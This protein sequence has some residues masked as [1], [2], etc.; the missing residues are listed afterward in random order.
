[1]V[2]RSLHRTHGVPI[3]QIVSLD[4]KSNM[5]RLPSLKKSQPLSF[6]RWETSL[7]PVQV[8]SSSDQ[9]QV[10]QDDFLPRVP[11]ETPH[12]GWLQTVE[13][14]LT[15]RSH[16]EILFREWTEISSTVTATT[17]FSP[18]NPSPP[19]RLAG[20]N[21]SIFCPPKLFRLE[22]GIDTIKQHSHHKR[23]I[24]WC[25]CVNFRDHFIYAILIFITPSWPKAARQ[26]DLLRLLN[27]Q[28]LGVFIVTSSVML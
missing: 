1:M 10:W 26:Q 17:V 13:T 15:Q 19:P 24:Q 22:S 9:S 20:K 2:T 18:H 12:L 5:S 16:L 23:Y 4:V 14:L 28:P 11:L 25:R 6:Q 21:I 7:L 3:C 8:A 27:K